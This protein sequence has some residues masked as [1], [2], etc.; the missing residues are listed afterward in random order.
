MIA[1]DVLSPNKPSYMA[2]D[3]AGPEL[4]TRFFKKKFKSRFRRLKKPQSGYFSTFIRPGAG[5]IE[6]IEMCK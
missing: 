4:T 2:D 1:S 5:A 3:Y 6:K